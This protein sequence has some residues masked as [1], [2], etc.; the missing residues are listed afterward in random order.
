L[1]GMAQM[2]GDP[3]GNVFRLGEVILWVIAGI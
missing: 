2:D 3:G 1:Q